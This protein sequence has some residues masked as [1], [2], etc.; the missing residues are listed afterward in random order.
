MK[1][2]AEITRRTELSPGERRGWNSTL[3]PISPKRQRTKRATDGPRADYVRKIWL[4]QVCGKRRAESCHEIASGG[5]RD[6]ALWL[7]SCWLAVCED[8]PRTG[9][10]GCH[11][12]IQHQPLVTQLAVKLWADP[13]TFDL[14]EVL[15]VKRLGPKAVTLSE[16][17]NELARIREERPWES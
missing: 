6:A 1:R 13:E 12:W 17:E 4:C 8:D 9:K 14:A 3:R 2:K 16:V 11:G 15:K 10:L 5:S 7:P